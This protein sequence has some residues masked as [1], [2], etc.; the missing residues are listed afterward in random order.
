M[1]QERPSAVRFFAHDHPAL[2]TTVRARIEQRRKEALDQLLFAQSWDDYN[3]RAGIV[4]A[5]DDTLELI[6]TVEKEL[7]DQ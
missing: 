6:G 4:R 3:R 2:A 5:F 1:A 7:S